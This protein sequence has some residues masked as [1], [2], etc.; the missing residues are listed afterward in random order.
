MNFI[1]VG[2]AGAKLR[3]RYKGIVSMHAGVH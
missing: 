2:L 3:G 1:F